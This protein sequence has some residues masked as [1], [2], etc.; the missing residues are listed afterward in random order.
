MLVLV[1]VLVPVLEL[2]LVA[3]A[4]VP[5]CRCEYT[6]REQECHLHNLV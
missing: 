6:P 5:S 3:R 1:L 4:A 2:V